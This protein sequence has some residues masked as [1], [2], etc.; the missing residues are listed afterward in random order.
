MLK[1]VAAFGLAALL[2]STVSASATLIDFED[3]PAGPSQFGNSGAQTLSYTF[4]SLTATFN[5]GVILTHEVLQ[6]TDN[7]NVYATISAI[8]AGN[9]TLTN[10]LTVTFNQPIQNF[11]IDILNAVAGDYELSDNAGHTAFFTLATTGGSV[12]TEGFAATGTVINITELNNVGFDVRTFDFAIDNVRFNEPLAGAVPE[13][14][15]WAMMILGFAGVGVMAYRRKS[16][17]ALMAA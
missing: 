17:P 10:P 8:N 11:S 13:P 3:Q 9:G 12:Q 5:G 14:S 2:L 15:T 7:S 4:G 1:L 16:K 6:S